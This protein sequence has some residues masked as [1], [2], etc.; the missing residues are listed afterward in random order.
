MRVEHG[1]LTQLLHQHDEYSQQVRVT[2][3]EMTQALSAAADEQTRLRAE[4]QVG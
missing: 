2:F 3:D 1:R 4:L